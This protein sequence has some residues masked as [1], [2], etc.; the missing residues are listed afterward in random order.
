MDHNWIGLM[1]FKKFAD[2]VLIGLNFFGAGLDSNWKI[3][4]SAY[5]RWPVATSAVDPWRKYFRNLQSLFLSIWV[6]QRVCVFEFE[7]WSGLRFWK[8]TNKIKRSRSIA[9]YLA[10]VLAATVCKNCVKCNCKSVQNLVVINYVM[11]HNRLARLAISW[12][13]LSFF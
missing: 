2:Q 5:L 4:H 7:L 6:V 10:G 12:P 9:Y 13:N 11:F 3:L 8:Q 1:I